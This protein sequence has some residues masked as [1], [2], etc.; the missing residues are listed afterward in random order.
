MTDILIVIW[1]HWIADFAMQTDK[2]ALNKSRDIWILF[3]HAWI[4][5][6]PFLL[7]GWKYA[8]F[9]GTIH[10][11][12]DFVTSKLTSYYWS[13]ENRHAFFVTIGFDQAVHISVLIGSLNWLT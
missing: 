2:I 4:Y 12:V 6:V 13:I 8:V 5:S 1:I 10:F 11:A 3:L 9:N 7:F